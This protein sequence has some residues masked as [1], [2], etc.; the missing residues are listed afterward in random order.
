MLTLYTR[1]VNI[2]NI[3]P[4]LL[5]ISVLALSCEHVSMVMHL[6]RASGVDGTVA[7]LKVVLLGRSVW[8]YNICTFEL[9]KFLFKCF[10]TYKFMCTSWEEKKKKKTRE[11]FSK[12]VYTVTLFSLII[13]WCN[14]TR[15]CQRDAAY[16][17]LCPSRREALNEKVT[18]H[19]PVKEQLPHQS[20]TW[21][22]EQAS[23]LGTRDA[24]GMGV[25]MAI[26]LMHMNSQSLTHTHTQRQDAWP[27]SLGM[28]DMGRE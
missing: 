21:Q 19:P 12:L 5:E 26:L 25:A 15:G 27:L 23:L 24:L 20:N 4:F 18:S 6:R 7:S 13:P 22:E 8:K 16:P 2:V 3:I 28:K 1:M 11:T 10:H 14:E 17:E 9:Y